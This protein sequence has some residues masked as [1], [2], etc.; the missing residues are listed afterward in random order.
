MQR[1]QQA[2]QLLLPAV[3]VLQALGE[4]GPQ[5]RQPGVT[6][7]GQLPERGGP[8][9]VGISPAV[10]PNPTSAQEDGGQSTRRGDGMEE[11]ERHR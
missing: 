7:A 4:A 10:D 5:R 3:R 8:D 6:L 11:A 2:A 1:G 9:Q